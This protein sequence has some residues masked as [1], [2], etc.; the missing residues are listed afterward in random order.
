LQAEKFIELSPVKQ[1]C[2]KT[3]YAWAAEGCFDPS[4]TKSNTF[5]LE[6]PPSSGKTIIVPEVDRSEWF[7]IREAKR[8]I[9]LK[10]IELID[11]LIEKLK[12]C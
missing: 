10:Q 4:T 6:W 1:K 3:I 7:K 11:E 12:F 5:E 9:N 8:K 2:G